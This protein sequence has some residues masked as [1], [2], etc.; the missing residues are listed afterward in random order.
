MTSALAASVVAS[1][2]TVADYGTGMTAPLYFRHAS[3]LEHDTGPHPEG[4]GRIPAIERAMKERGWLG[5]ERR[6]APVV[7]LDVLRAVHPQSHIDHVRVMSERGGGSL[8]PDTVASPGSY[9]A[10]LHAAGGAVAMVDALLAGEAP[11]AFCGLR[12]PGHHA[13]PEAAMGFCLFNNVAVA[14]RHVLDSHGLARVFILDWD[15]H[16]GNGTNDVFHETSAVLFASVHQSP[17]YP[18]TGPL[19]DVGSGEG[20]GFSINLPVPP[21]SGEPEWLSLVEHVV[22]PAARAFEP[23]LVLVSAGFDAHRADP[24]ASCTL[25]TSSFALLALHVRA[26]AEDLGAPVGVVLEGGYALEALSQSVVAA[27]AALADGDAPASVERDSLT[28]R[29]A[30]QVGRYWSL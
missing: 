4:P 13:E 9:R 26:L 7:D 8:D 22:M 11:L 21:G 1:C 5:F 12:P 19:S 24:L 18:G 29:A 10:A 27:L 23:Q 17:L 6:D 14:A 25:E 15:V 2:A 28:D 20:E 16:H 30:A 3:S